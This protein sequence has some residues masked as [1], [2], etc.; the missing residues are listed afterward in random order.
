MGTDMHACKV[1]LVQTTVSWQ[2]MQEIAASNTGCRRQ[3]HGMKVD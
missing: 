2:R 1:L 3:L